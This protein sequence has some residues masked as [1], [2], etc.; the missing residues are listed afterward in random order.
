VVG[1]LRLLGLAQPEV[2]GRTRQV[3]RLDPRFGKDLGVATFVE[4]RLSTAI[5]IMHEDGLRLE[6]VASGCWTPPIKRSSGLVSHYGS[7]PSSSSLIGSIPTGK[8][9]APDDYRDF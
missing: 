9:Q 6:D 2:I 3:T 8:R 4:L 7:S 5:A 1:W